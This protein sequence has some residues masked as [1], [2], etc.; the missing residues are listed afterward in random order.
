M[1]KVGQS[2]PSVA[3]EHH[4]EADRPSPSPPSDHGG[5]TV[6]GLHDDLWDLVESAPDALL[7]IGAGGCIAL[8]NRE[9]E[10]MF[11]HDRADLLG[12]PVEALLPERYRAAHSAHRG[13]FGRQPSRRPMGVGLDLWALR[14]DGTE[15]PVEV[16]LSPSSRHDENGRTIVAVREAT[17]EADTE[18]KLRE[19]QI[20]FRGAFDNGPVP[21]AIVDLTPPLDR[22]ILEVNQA[23]ADLL[24][25]TTSEMIGMSFIELTHP[26]DRPAD[27]EAVGLMIGGATD[28]Y[29]PVKRYLRSDGSVVWVQ[30]HAAPLTRR[31]GS[32]L[33]IAHAIDIT[34]RVRAEAASQR[35]EA[36]NLAVSEIRLAMLRGASE[37]EGL[38]LIARL[39]AECL[40]AE[41]TLIL[42]RPSQGERP[43]VAASYHIA[44]AAGSRLVFTDDGGVVGE[45]FRSGEAQVCGPDDPRFTDI[46]RVVVDQYPVESIVVAPMHDGNETVGI[47]IMVRTSGSDRLDTSDLEAIERFA[48]EAVVAIELARVAEARQRLEL[49]ED[50]E[51]VGRDIHDKVISRLFAT[52]MSLQAM[53]TLLENGEQ[54]RAL[55]AVAEIDSAIQEIRATIYGL[56]SQLDWG[57]GVRGE[58]LGLVAGQRA[59]LGFE[60]T[61][62]LQGDLDGVASEVVTELL[63]TL[64]EALTNTAKHARATNVAVAV[65]A[66]DDL[67]ELTVADNGVGF[68]V[69]PDGRSSRGALTNHGVANMLA[70][71]EQLGG[72]ATVSSSPAGGTTIRWETPRAPT[73][74]SS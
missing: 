33:G 61:V 12:L 72:R 29:S 27:D 67:V 20:R 19:S 58:V 62:D 35:H 25:Y 68:D 69:R 31:D 11:G 9:A 18:A 13:R 52:G 30:L 57:R 6:D 49:L 44:E 55:G 2:G 34:E 8:A 1:A 14:S 46:N 15:F 24:G 43:A 50:R 32:V 47:I 53:A 17:T 26:D 71:A 28:R 42:T 37:E 4:A 16:S 60:P 21:T 48:S 45:V 10:R 3:P 51:R 36:L 65:S 38:A 63:A 54:E 23:M 7:V 66:T 39:S 70:R 41:G 40:G 22:T 73:P 56:R 5:T 64:R 59:A 74:V